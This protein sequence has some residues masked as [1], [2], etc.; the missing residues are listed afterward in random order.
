MMMKVEELVGTTFFNLFITTFLS[1]PSL[2]LAERD[3]LCGSLR[4]FSRLPAVLCSKCKPCMYC[5]LPYCILTLTFPWE[6]AHHRYIYI[7]V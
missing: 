1:R 7:A 2:F 6:G 3:N 5:V 4:W